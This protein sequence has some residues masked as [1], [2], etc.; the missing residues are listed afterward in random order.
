M[1]RN[2]NF[3]CTLIPPFN[4]ICPIIYAC[5]YG[6][7]LKFNF[8]FICILGIWILCWLL[9]LYINYLCIILE[10]PSSNLSITCSTAHYSSFFQAFLKDFLNW[11]NI[12]HYI[13][14]FHK[15]LFWFISFL[16]FFFSLFL[17]YW[18]NSFYS[19]AFQYH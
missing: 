15:S 14:L 2:S 13:C 19:L 9:I 1:C 4:R 11:R 17:S 8:F 5:T 6:S 12:H 16:I 7:R 3:L 10:V 18:Q